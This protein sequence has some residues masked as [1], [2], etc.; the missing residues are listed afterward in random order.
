MYDYDLIAS[1]LLYFYLNFFGVQ[2]RIEEHG[3]GDNGGV[4]DAENAR[5]SKKMMKETIG[6]LVQRNRKQNTRVEELYFQ[7]IF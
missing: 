3:G 2:R 5:E 6:D 7:R 1:L 4:L